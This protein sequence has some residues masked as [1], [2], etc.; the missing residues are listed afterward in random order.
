MSQLYVPNPIETDVS[1]FNFSQKNYQRSHKR[2]EINQ[3]QLV[4]LVFNK[5]Q[6]RHPCK[7]EIVNDSFNGCSLIIREKWLRKCDFNLQREQPFYNGKKLLI[8]IKDI[9]PINAEIMWS[10]E[11]DNHH[12]RIGVKYLVSKLLK[13]KLFFKKTGIQNIRLTS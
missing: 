9:E 7:G 13:T 5:S 11:L 1:T 4:K 10:K 12:V 8:L 3:G 2:L 6:V